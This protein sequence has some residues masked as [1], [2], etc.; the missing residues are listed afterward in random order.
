MRPTAPPTLAHK[1]AVHRTNSS[2]PRGDD[3]NADV[4]TDAS[5]SPST[6]RFAQ[7]SL[8]FSKINPPSNPVQNDFRFLLV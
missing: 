5:H 4:S 8:S 2:P 7:K 6:V 3:V 1:R